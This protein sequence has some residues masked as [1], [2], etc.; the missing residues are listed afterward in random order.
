MIDYELVN[1]FAERPF[2]GSP[3]CVVPDADAL[4]AEAMQALAREVNTTETAFVGPPS[5]TDAAYRVRVFTPA[6]ETARGG[7]SGVGTAA[8]LVR[9]GMVPAGSVIQECGTGGRQHLVAAADRATLVGRDPLPVA[10]VDAEPLLAAAGL[11][12]EDLSG[13]APR[14][15]GLST[16]FPFLPV[17]DAAVAGARPDYRR[18][19]E[20]GIPA[21]FLFSW[22]PRLRSAHARLFAPGFGIPE[23][24][25]CAPLALAL[26]VWLTDAGLLPK[27][28]GTH[29]YLITQ[30]AE[31]GRRAALRCTTEVSDGRISRVAATGSVS[32]V[33]SGRIAVPSPS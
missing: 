6:G 7:H 13:P 15:A 3:L 11:T 32:P 14:A 20:A 28:D 2:A 22:D 31:T 19:S 24:P 12:E 9:L 30:G 17:R 10:D 1:M 16:R 8:T 26:G 18:M 23:D 4:P 21:L 27:T 25:A 5:S 29:E 33:A